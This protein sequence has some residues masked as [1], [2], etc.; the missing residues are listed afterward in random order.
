[1]SGLAKYL[2]L[3][4]CVFQTGVLSAQ[5][6]KVH[7]E[8]R[9]V[10]EKEIALL[11]EQLAS[12]ASKSR[13]ALSKLTLVKKKV[14]N[15]KV[16]IQ[17]TD[18]EIRDYSDRIFQ[19]QRQINKLQARVDTLTVH[20]ARLVNSAY[21]NRDAKVWYMYILASEDL[22][23]AFRRYSYFKTLSQRMKE[24]A[25]KI[26]E[27]QS[28][29]SKEKSAL[30]ELK[31]G[32]Q[33]VKKMREA[34]LVTLEAEQRQSQNV[35]SQLK[36]NRKKYEAELAS[37]RK[38]VIALNKEIERLV[39]EAMKAAD[40]SSK[41]A[42]EVDYKLA[43]EFS[44]NQGK[45]P[46]PVADGVIVDRFGQHYH[47]VFTR[48]KLPFNNGIGI[49]V[50]KDAQVK[51]VFDG[52]VK[53]IVLMPGYNLCV[54]VQHGNYFTF[55]C[56]LKTTSV[57]AGSKIKIGDTIGTVD[58]INGDTQLHFQVWKGQTPQNPELWLRKK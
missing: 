34:E 28:E 37:K 24:Q 7:E 23:Q 46:W 31:S 43:A 16:L 40:K 44:S 27:V 58:T 25:V 50:R 10:L 4:V 56:K 5:N 14:A 57:K 30:M 2:V 12:N 19:T 1:M 33:Q 11:D 36:R 48:V 49:A 45:L 35:V 8:R 17:E 13:S 39:A 22:G 41:A 51:A 21:K 9:A 54:L 53:Q 29:L 32:A 38:Q 18:K 26:R 42:K 55:Y 20:Y 6:I 3:L 52:V 47:P 15:R